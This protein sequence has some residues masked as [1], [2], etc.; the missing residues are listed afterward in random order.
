[1]QCVYNY[2]QHCEQKLEDQRPL[3]E[4]NDQLLTNQAGKHPKGNEAAQ[5]SRNCVLCFGHS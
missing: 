2:L 5:F 4:A 1:M 3:R